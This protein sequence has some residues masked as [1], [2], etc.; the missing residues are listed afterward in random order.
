MVKS[1][2]EFESNLTHFAIQFWFDFKK[3]RETAYF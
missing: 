3:E 2:L 1:V